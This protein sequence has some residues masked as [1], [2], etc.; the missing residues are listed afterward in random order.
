MGKM[1]AGA[2]RRVSNGP[3]R[4]KVAVSL[5]VDAGEKLDA[6]RIH[7]ANKG[8]FNPRAEGNYSEIAFIRWCRRMPLLR[9]E[10]RGRKRRV[11]ENLVLELIPSGLP[12]FQNELSLSF[13]EEI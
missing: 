10:K 7:N 1:A 9:A 12:N 4:V 3:H 13:S 8:E 6:S 11:S 5:I 2:R